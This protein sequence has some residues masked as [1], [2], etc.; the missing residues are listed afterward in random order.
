MVCN[1]PA[2]PLK[3]LLYRHFEAQV[4]AIIYV[5]RAFG[6]GRSGARLRKTKSGSSRSLPIVS[7]V[8]PFFGLT[9]SI[10]RILKGNPKKG[11]TM[12]TTGNI[13]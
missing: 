12:E 1:F 7:I 2:T 5:H 6:K 11:T 9:N 3:R 4:Y 10:L 8:V 13:Q